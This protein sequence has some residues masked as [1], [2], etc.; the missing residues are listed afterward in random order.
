MLRT[1]KGEEEIFYFSFCCLLS[2]FTASS[3]YIES[4]NSHFPSLCC[5]S[6]EYS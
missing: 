1:T 2:L 5:F 3:S 6:I 4:K